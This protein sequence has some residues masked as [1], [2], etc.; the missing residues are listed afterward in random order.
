MDHLRTP[1]SG[2]GLL[3]EG[4]RTASCRRMLRS[5]STKTGHW[6]T[7]GKAPAVWNTHDGELHSKP[8]F[9]RMRAHLQRGQTNRD[10]T[11]E[12]SA[13]LMRVLVTLTGT[14]LQAKLAPFRPPR[15]GYGT[16]PEGIPLCYVS[17]PVGNIG[18]TR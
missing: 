17:S 7:T 6:P 12:R 13:R 18:V 14:H 15:R 4:E 8:P 9:D 5:K 10:A 16:G 11:L 3:S 2:I 1:V